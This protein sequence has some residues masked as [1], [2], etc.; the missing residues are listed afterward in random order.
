M[1]I[2]YGA[3]A[4][5]TN[6]EEMMLHQTASGNQVWAWQRFHKS[7]SHVQRLE[8]LICNSRDSDRAL[9]IEL[10]HQLTDVYCEGGTAVAP[11]EI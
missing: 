10:E 2:A 1:G 9:I 3:Q 8:G 11:R 6:P 5:L 4:F 7:I